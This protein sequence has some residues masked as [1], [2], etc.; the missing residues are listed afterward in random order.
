MQYL[1]DTNVVSE[2]LRPKPSTN[3]MRRLH[4]HD[5]E[6]AIPALV[7]HELRYGWARLPKSRRRD[8]IERFIEDVVRTS[9][10]V[11]EYDR[12]AADWHAMERARLS[13][14]G[15]TPPFVDGQIA[16]IAHVN[17]LTL[18]TSNIGHFREFQSLRLLDW[19]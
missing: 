8:A 14:G 6:I 17:G 18:V 9:F 5:G 1:L 12:E 4:A 10:P 19:A 11:I 7:W 3:I 2:P 16:A 15:K 13:A